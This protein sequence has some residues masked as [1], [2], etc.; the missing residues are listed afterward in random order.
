MKHAATRHLRQFLLAW[1]A[2]QLTLFEFAFAST[3]TLGVSDS[4]RELFIV[5]Q[6]D[7]LESDT[8]SWFSGDFVV[9]GGGCWGGDEDDSQASYSQTVG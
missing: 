6:V 9:A 8:N 2:E 7:G 1:A 3:L 4:F 5:T